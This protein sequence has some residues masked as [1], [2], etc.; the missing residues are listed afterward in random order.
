MTEEFCLAKVCFIQIKLIVDIHYDEFGNL[1]FCKI[2]M[3]ED[4]QK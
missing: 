2:L 1:E 4:S 3:N